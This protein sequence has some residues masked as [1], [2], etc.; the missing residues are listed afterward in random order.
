MRKMLSYALVAAFVAAGCPGGSFAR[1]AEVEPQGAQAQTMMTCS[2][3]KRTTHAK[4]QQE[5]VPGTTTTTDISNG[6]RAEF[7]SD[8]LEY[9][10]RVGRTGATIEIQDLTSGMLAKTDDMGVSR[11]GGVKDI[12]ISLFNQKGG[13]LGDAGT[14]VLTLTCRVN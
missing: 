12:S 10:V 1:D 8:Q 14:K 6:G 11:I 4:L 2:V 5:N 9:L 13:L 7:G 3:S